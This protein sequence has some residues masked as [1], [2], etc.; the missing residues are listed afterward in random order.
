M[1]PKE[2]K[3][4]RLNNRLLARLAR[5]MG[6]ALP[7]LGL[8]RAKQIREGKALLIVIRNGY[9]SECKL[10]HRMYVKLTPPTKKPLHKLFKK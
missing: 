10:R 4:I 6:P 1:S 3:A 7:R 5:V 8:P 2:K 9:C